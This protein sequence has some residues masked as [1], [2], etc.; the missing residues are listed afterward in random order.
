MRKI[1][2]SAGSTAQVIALATCVWFCDFLCLACAFGA[3][4]APVPWA[5]VLLA[6]G[7]AQ[8]AGSLPVVPGGLG[9]IEGS[10]AVVLVAYGSARVPAIA[11]ALAYRMVSFWLAIAVG[12]AS[13]GVIAHRARPGRAAPSAADDPRA[14]QGSE[15][16]PA[17]VDPFTP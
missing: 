12:W 16:Q 5:G 4:H 6:Y 7:V 10:L 1:P 2:L 9:I 15:G 3:V 14:D 8:V 11:A 17:A 13:V